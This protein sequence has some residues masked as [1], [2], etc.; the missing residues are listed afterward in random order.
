MARVGIWNVPTKAVDA[1]LA[2]VP[3][4]LAEGSISP[5]AA[6]PSD[7]YVGDIAISVPT[8]RLAPHL[9]WHRNF[10]RGL[11]ALAKPAV[12][13]HQSGAEPHQIRAPLAA[14]PHLNFGPY[15]CNR[16][17]GSV[18]QFVHFGLSRSCCDFFVF[19]RVTLGQTGEMNLGDQTSFAPLCEKDAW[20][21]R[22]FSA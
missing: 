19:K 12:P 9:R 13:P 20:A 15:R 21:S 1:R 14:M 11:C 16:S 18:G 3:P 22:D 8:F 2:G 10:E 7:V 6:S 4:S 17:A 5:L